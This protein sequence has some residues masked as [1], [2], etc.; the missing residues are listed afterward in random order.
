M[1][2]FD[3]SGTPSEPSSGGEYEEI[4]KRAE[5]EGTLSR[6]ET[7]AECADR[8]LS[9]SSFELAGRCLRIATHYAMMS[10]RHDVAG[11]LSERARWLG[12]E[13]SSFDMW[14]RNELYRGQWLA[15]QGRARE[16]R[17][18]ALQLAELSDYMDD[19]GRQADAAHLL[20]LSSIQFGE[21]SS[22]E[23]AIR[24]LLKLSSRIAKSSHYA[25][26]ALGLRAYLGVVRLEGSSDQDE[27][28]QAIASA[29]EY[30]EAVPPHR[31]SDMHR[32]L[33]H[34]AALQLEL[35]QLDEADKTLASAE[36]LSG[37]ERG[38]LQSDAFLAALRGRYFL[39]RGRV[40]E[41]EISFRDALDR[42]SARN[43][44]GATIDSWRARW[45]LAKCAAVEGDSTHAVPLY[46]EAIDEMLAA[47]RRSSED[48][49]SYLGARWRFLEEVASVLLTSGATLEAYRLTLALDSLVLG[50]GL[51]AALP[52]SEPNSAQLPRTATE[53]LQVESSRV[54]KIRPP[55]WR[56]EN[57]PPLGEDEVFVAVSGRTI[58]LQ[59]GPKVRRYSFDPARPLA[60]LDGL[61]ARH[62]YISANRHW[63]KGLLVFAE[64]ARLLDRHTVSLVPHP[65]MISG[66]PVRASPESRIAIFGS[67]SNFGPKIENAERRM[68]DR[69]GLD[70]HMGGKMP[71]LKAWRPLDALLFSG[72]G[73]LDTGSLWDSRLMLAPDRPLTLADWL[74]ARVPVRLAIL[75]ACTTASPTREAS[76]HWFGF[77]EGMLEAGTDTVLAAWGEVGTDEALRFVGRFLDEGG[78]EA[79]A[80]AYRTTVRALEA[81]GDPAARRFL[82]FGRRGARRTAGDPTPD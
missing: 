62:I 32:G 3:D 50:P 59:E 8:L 57:L 16:T 23:A 18:L 52:V 14:A 22:A 49:G 71:E 9:S 13:L 30:L 82:L 40:R 33:G 2:E 45:G 41:A 10:S 58:F 21:W 15:N 26:A 76:G 19:T 34:L 5:E 74:E 12:Y 20:A 56:E 7:W 27:L 80:E 6:V 29:G 77:A 66:E 63:E 69:V 73:E 37:R 46:L 24:R 75:S 4:V 48:A 36:G 44:G 64:G 51:A 55:Q 81:K 78:L 1:L 61:D 79:P 70:K 31:T 67:G 39:A 43:Q 42:E 11:C 53:C 68:A 25:R 38:A 47:G 17:K 65:S 72:H 28:A 54:G 35:G 60:S